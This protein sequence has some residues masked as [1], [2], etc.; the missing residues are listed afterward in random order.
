MSPAAISGSAFG[1][2]A[3]ADMGRFLSLIVGA[4]ALLE[5]PG[6]AGGKRLGIDL[7]GALHAPPAPE[8]VEQLVEPGKLRTA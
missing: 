3:V 2:S 7:H 4:G 5:T 1:S 6:R 8:G